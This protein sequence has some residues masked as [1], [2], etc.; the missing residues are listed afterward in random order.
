MTKY[1]L[2]EGVTLTK[3]D[4]IMTYWR[5]IDLEKREALIE[6][7]LQFNNI[8]YPTIESDK[9]EHIFILFDEGSLICW[10]EIKLE[11][12]LHKY[13]QMNFDDYF[14]EDLKQQ[15][16]TLDEFS[17][18]ITGM[19]YDELEEFVGEYYQ[20]F[21]SNHISEREE[22]VIKTFIKE[23]LQVV[24]E[25]GKPYRVEYIHPEG[26]FMWAVEQMKQGKEL[27]AKS[28]KQS[29]IMNGFGWM[30]WK[31]TK[32][33]YSPSTGDMESTDW[34]IYEEN[35]FGCF[36]V[37]DCSIYSNNYGQNITPEYFDDLEKAIK[38]ARELKDE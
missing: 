9:K 29:I 23:N 1:K 35:K 4:F 15:S 3:E 24:H 5:I 17:N 22:E 27:R 13:K 30:F 32:D 7:S 6:H 11:N 8:R 25:D 38:R 2:K 33:R 28:M 12:T 18:E 21:L 10:E 26:T 19:Y 36:E 16:L 34:E 20:E 14:E 31:G 37:I